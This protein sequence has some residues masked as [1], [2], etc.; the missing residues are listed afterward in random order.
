MAVKSEVASLNTRVESIEENM[1]TKARVDGIEHKM[2]T[3][4]DVAGLSERIGKLETGQKLIYAFLLT[5]MA[6]LVKL[7]FFP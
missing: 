4:A 3:K 6:M 1:A 5:M 7:V 2:A